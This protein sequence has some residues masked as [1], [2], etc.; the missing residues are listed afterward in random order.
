MPSWT[1]TTPAAADSDFA[2]A[3]EICEGALT[4]PSANDQLEARLFCF[5]MPALDILASCIERVLLCL[6]KRPPQENAAAEK[7][8]EQFVVSQRRTKV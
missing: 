7:R 2:V 5:D 1:R 3:G 4:P 6:L 8:E